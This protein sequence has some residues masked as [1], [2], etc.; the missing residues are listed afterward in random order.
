MAGKPHTQ[1]NLTI[2]QIEFALTKSRGLVTP[3]AEALNVTY[4]AIYSRISKSRR[5][6]RLLSDVREAMLD[7]CEGTLLDYIDDK[8]LTAVIYYLKTIGKSRGYSERHEVSG[9]DGD[10]VKI[11]RIERVI[12]D[13]EP[14]AQ[15]NPKKLSSSQ[16]KAAKKKHAAH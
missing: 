6:Q 10:S 2:D 16:K 4:Q 15:S 5:L 13:V 9:I 3:A 8:N 12:I 11:E 1:P 7:R 14:I